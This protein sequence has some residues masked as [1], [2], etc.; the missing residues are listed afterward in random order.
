METNLTIGSKVQ[1]LEKGQFYLRIGY[2]RHINFANE[3]PFLVDFKNG[4]Y[5]FHENHLRKIDLNCPDY[6]KIHI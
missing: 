3:Y 4:I 2:I 5:V 1:N 6:L